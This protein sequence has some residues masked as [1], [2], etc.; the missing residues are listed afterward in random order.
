MWIGFSLLGVYDVFEA[1]FSYFYKKSK[2]VTKRE[3]L[4]IPTITET[5]APLSGYNDRS[6]YDEDYRRQMRRKMWQRKAKVAA[7]IERWTRSP[8]NMSAVSH[9]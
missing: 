4:V 6:Y 8:N 2:E 7:I 3:E 5:V 9:H 1:V